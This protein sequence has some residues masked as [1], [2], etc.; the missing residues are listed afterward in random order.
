MGF[1]S[2]SAKVIYDLILGSLSILPIPLVKVQAF[3]NVLAVCARRS[4]SIH[5]GEAFYLAQ[6]G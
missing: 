2:L 5:H 1:F 6:G 3:G 4:L